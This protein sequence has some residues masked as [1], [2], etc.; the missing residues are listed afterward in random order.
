[1]SARRPRRRHGLAL[2]AALLIGA[3]QAATLQVGPGRGYASIAQAAQ[4]AREGD[5]VEV[6]AGEYR[7]DVAIWAQ[8]RLVLRAVGGRVR[9][10]ADGAIAEGKALWVV[11]GGDIRVE[12]FDF[13]GARAPWRN[14]AG[15]RFESGRLQVV[16]CSFVDNE[17]GIL[18]AGDPQAELVIERSLFQ[19]NGA[20]DGQSHNL[21]VGTIGQLRV[22]DSQFRDARVGHL[23]KSRAAINEIHRNLLV[24]SDTGSAS[25]ELEFPSGGVARVTH[26]LLRQGPRTENETMV[27]FGAEGYR[28]ARNELVLHDNQL[29]D[30]RPEGGVYLWVAPGDRTVDVQGNR[31]QGASRTRAQVLAY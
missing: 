9:L 1:M 29:V 13:S 19:G 11:R 12:G 4:A 23:L 31:L 30:D 25:Y 17:N 16:D 7:A 18:T 20:G 10:I 24:D 22:T 5:T 14:G 27:S 26:N 28:W 2:A 21:Y 8:Q 3:A 15:I 6:Q